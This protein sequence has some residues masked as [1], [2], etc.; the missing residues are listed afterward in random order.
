MEQLIVATSTDWQQ[1]RDRE[2]LT[3][4][5]PMVFRTADVF[6]GGRSAFG[7]D[8]ARADEAWHAIDKNLGALA[9]FFDAVILRRQLPIFSYS[10]TFP[11][12]R[13]LDAAVTG[14]LLVPTVVTGE[15][16][17]RSKASALSVVRGGVRLP[18]A[19]ER[20][21]LQEL[22]AFGW[23]WQPGLDDLR[24]ARSPDAPLSPA[25]ERLLT[26]LL[27]GVLFAGYAQQLSV[28][29][30]PFETQAEHVLQPKR[31]RLFLAAS[32]ATRHAN[33]GDD[34]R[35][36]LGRFRRLARLYAEENVHVVELPA[37]PS[38]LP[39]L[40]RDAVARGG[41]SPRALLRAAL[42]WREK[43]S[44]E[45]FRTWYRQIEKELHR[46]FRPPEL[47]RELVALSGDIAREL[48][49]GAER[50]I[51]VSAKIK[52]SAE[53]GLQPKA[54]VTAEVGGETEI[55]PDRMRWFFQGLLPGYGYRKLLVRMATA[56]AGYAHARR[57][58]AT[59]ADVA[60]DHAAVPG[61][62]SDHTAGDASYREMAT[63]LRELWYAS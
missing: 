50:T 45:A 37:A 3:I 10:A 13:L 12:S 39:L 49:K 24:T 11:E 47:D 60:D 15:V 31:S 2:L 41:A 5:D 54:G 51:T 48:G 57:P 32:L 53:A 25:H 19:I 22:A 6:V 30:G 28:R 1:L 52:A 36:L 34:E 21:M 38:F 14:D 9:H 27:G 23:D 55:A 7:S 17:E 63:H 29:N 56:H 58:A 61:V 59:A 18:E 33:G 46:D 16:Y 62:V 44:V 20:N 8:E 42:A 4:L 43:R 40:L 26:F 35:I